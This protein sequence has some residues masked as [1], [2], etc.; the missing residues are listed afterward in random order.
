M[1]RTEI[2]NKYERITGKQAVYNTA[3]GMEYSIDFIKWLTE[4]RE[5]YDRLMSGKSKMTMQEMANFIG[6]PI[7]VDWDGTVNA[8]GAEPIVRLDSFLWA[9]DANDVMEIPESMVDYTGVWKDS[10]TLPDGWEE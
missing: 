7:T 5:A 4:G 8:H 3:F 10:L 2:M 6:Y 1:D 9:N